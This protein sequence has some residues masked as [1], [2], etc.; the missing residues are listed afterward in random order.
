MFLFITG[1]TASGKSEYAE[2][3]ALELA[4][5]ST[6]IYAATMTDRSDESLERIKRHRRRR[7]SG[8]ARGGALQNTRDGTPQADVPAYETFECFSLKDAYALAACA[9]GRT[10]LLDCFSGLASDIMFADGAM[11][12]AFPDADAAA[13][14]LIRAA[15]ALSHSCANLI[16]VSDMVFSDGCRY[17]AAV[18]AYIEALGRA[19]SAAANMADSV[20]EVVCGIPVKLK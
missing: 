18:E 11:H 19:C 13:D 3:C 9:D 17:D 1:G 6:V 10:V 15:E 12:P 2:K 16:I 14:A 7:R 20:I 5:G 8:S 4:C